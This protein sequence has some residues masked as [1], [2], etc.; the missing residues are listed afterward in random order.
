MVQLLSLI[1]NLISYSISVGFSRSLTYRL[2]A[3]RCRTIHRY[4]YTIHN[5]IKLA[6]P[7]LWWR[8]LFEE[9]WKSPKN[10]PPLLC[11][12]ILQSLDLINKFIERRSVLRD[13]KEGIFW[14]IARYKSSSSFIKFC[15]PISKLNL[16]KCH[17]NKWLCL[18]TWRNMN[19]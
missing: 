17:K 12:Q 19:V 7:Y 13:F 5:P 6:L 8:S 4:M 2:S 11:P 15:S 16:K 1:S 18:A 9:Q 10:R 14:S 3:Y